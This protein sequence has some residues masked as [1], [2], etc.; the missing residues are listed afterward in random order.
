MNKTGTN[1]FCDVQGRKPANNMAASIE[2]FQN[3][4]CAAA[5]FSKLLEYALLKE[6]RKAIVGKGRNCSIN[7]RRSI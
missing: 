2:S 3:K 5:F 4:E 1:W 7:L 6:K